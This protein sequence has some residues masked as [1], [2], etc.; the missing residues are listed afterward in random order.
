METLVDKNNYVSEN[1]ADWR[2]RVEKMNYVSLLMSHYNKCRWKWIFL[3]MNFYNVNDGWFSTDSQPHQHTH[4]QTNTWTGLKTTR[5]LTII[6]LVV[7]SEWAKI[8]TQWHQAHGFT[9]GATAVVFTVFCLLLSLVFWRRLFGEI[10][11]AARTMPLNAVNMNLF[12]P[13][14]WLLGLCKI[15]KPLE[16]ASIQ[17]SMFLPLPLF[18]AL[19][20][21]WKN[22]NRN[23]FEPGMF[24]MKVN[25]FQYTWFLVVAHFFPFVRFT[26]PS[27]FPLF[28]FSW[29]W[30]KS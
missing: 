30:R 3:S 4:K 13:L 25:E 20:K 21:C 1:I 18:L 15:E 23:C 9:K 6:R 17:F 12:R 22:M 5:H 24:G 10:G 2:Y 28:Q 7:L 14:V 19:N 16:Y 26:S 27:P 11:C 29:N 8:I